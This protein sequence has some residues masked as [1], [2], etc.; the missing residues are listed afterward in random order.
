VSMICEPD[1]IPA[2][3]T[4]HNGKIA[5]VSRARQDCELVRRRGRGALQQHGATNDFCGCA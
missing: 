1:G 4:N 2:K 5:N 3:P